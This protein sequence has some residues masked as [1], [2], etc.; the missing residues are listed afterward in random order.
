M[1]ISWYDINELPMQQ[2]RRYRADR[3][4]LFD[5]NAINSAYCMKYHLKPSRIQAIFKGSFQPG[6]HLLRLLGK[7]AVSGRK[8]QGERECRL[9]RAENKHAQLLMQS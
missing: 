8:G 3:R 9:S 6:I 7:I 1:L 4:A 2:T 5:N